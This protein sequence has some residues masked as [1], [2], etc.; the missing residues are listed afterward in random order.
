MKIA[1]SDI[2]M[3]STRTYLRKDEVKESL[4]I[5]VGQPNSPGLSGTDMVSISQKAESLFKI[6]ENEMDET[7]MTE[8]M[9]DE[10]SLKKLIAEILLGKKIDVVRIERINEDVANISTQAN[11]NGSQITQQQGWGLQYDAEKTFQEKEDVRFDTKGI[12]KTADGRDIVFVLRLDMNREYLEKENVNIRAGD[13][14]ID[15][16]IINY[17]GNAAD[18]TNLKFDFDLNTDGKYEKIS[19]PNKGSGF[20]AIDLNDDGMINNGAELFGPSTG[21]GFG[22]L[23][24]YDVD[25]NDWIDENDQIHEDLRIMSV[26]DQGQSSLKTLK[27]MSIGAI[28]LGRSSTQFDMRTKEDNSLLG[29]VRSTGIYVHE[30]GT[31]GTI[32]QLDLVV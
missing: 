15:P 19:I 23:S 1:E 29:Q 16:L 28:Y 27:D 25:G 31:P 7:E 12:I 26:D 14:A 8:D 30:D 21:S 18:L 24:S 17:S 10:I 22:E 32:Q 9:D 2:R 4:R 13:A 6:F 20:L 3:S 11:G 5:W